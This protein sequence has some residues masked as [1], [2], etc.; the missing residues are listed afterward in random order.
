MCESCWESRDVVPGLSY[1]LFNSGSCVSAAALAWQ[2]RIVSS[3]VLCCWSWGSM[4]RGC[5]GIGR[6]EV[7]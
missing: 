2:G 7:L 3:V 1:L 6:G 5:I 4:A